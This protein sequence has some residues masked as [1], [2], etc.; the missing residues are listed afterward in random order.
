MILEKIRFIIIKFQFPLGYYKNY[1]H[2]LIKSG[3]IKLYRS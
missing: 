3:Q 2:I 1:R